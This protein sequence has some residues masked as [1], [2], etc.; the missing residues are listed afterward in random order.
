MTTFR[1]NKRVTITDV[2]PNIVFNK[3]SVTHLEDDVVNRS[4]QIKSSIAKNDLTVIAS[5]TK[6]L[7]KKPEQQSVFRRVI[8]DFKRPIQLEV[9]SDPI[10]PLQQPLLDPA[11]LKELIGSIRTLTEKLDTLSLGAINT[12]S[13]LSS[14][15]KDTSIP[16]YIPQSLRTGDVLESN[17]QVGEKSERTTL[18]EA[19]NSL[20]KLM[21]GK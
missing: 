7:V 9:I 8:E 6:H 16:T 4:Q 14:T 13:S 21:R 5:S 1:C 20:K 11:L 2:T 19:E 15:N 18:S 17:I 12:T 10:I 3:G